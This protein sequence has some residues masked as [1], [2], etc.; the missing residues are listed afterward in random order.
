[1]LEVIDL[2]SCSDDHPIPLLFVHGGWH[3]ASCWANFLDF[4]ADAGYRAVAM[5][6]RGH[7]ASACAKRFHACSIA[8]FVDDVRVTAD[9]LGGRPILVAHS[10]GGFVVQRYLETHQ[11]PAA[12]LLAS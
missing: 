9:D 1:M 4:F 5:S 10:L 2:G 12:V 6:L 11:A 3:S 8:D 7:G